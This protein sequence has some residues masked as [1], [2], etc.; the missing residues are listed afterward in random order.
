MAGVGSRE[1][2]AMKIVR[3]GKDLSKRTR[4]VT[5]E[6]CEAVLEYGPEDVNTDGINAEMQGRR[7]SFWVVCPACGKHAA[8]RA[9]G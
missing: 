5:C 9:F 8:V 7:Q 3:P 1:D 6:R 2:R 4:E